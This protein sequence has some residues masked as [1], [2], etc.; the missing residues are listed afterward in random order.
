MR[1]SSSYF[2]KSL[3]FLNSSD[4]LPFKKP[5]YAKGWPVQSGSYGS[6]C[7]KVFTQQGADFYNQGQADQYNNTLTNKFLNG[8]GA[9]FDFV[10]YYDSVLRVEYS[11]NNNGGL[12]G[13]RRRN[14]FSCD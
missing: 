11:F 3:G 13:K 4:T 9:G 6:L 1:S 7:L 14:L 8:V 10:T 2:P 12:F 5:L